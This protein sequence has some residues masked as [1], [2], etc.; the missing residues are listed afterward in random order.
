MLIH[1][2]GDKLA[3]SLPV[4]D[5]S[6]TWRTWRTAPHVGLRFNRTFMHDG[7]ARTV[8]EAILAHDGPGSEAAESVSIYRGLSDSERKTL[9]DFVGGL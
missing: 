1:D 2:M 9:D 7:R 6:A 5:G 4:T 3:D 8:N